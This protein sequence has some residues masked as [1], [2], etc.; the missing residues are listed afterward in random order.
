MKTTFL[1][2]L[3]PYSQLRYNSTRSFS[4]GEAEL[5]EVK[6]FDQDYNDIQ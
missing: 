2:L 4:G 1:L 6:C 5:R 3:I